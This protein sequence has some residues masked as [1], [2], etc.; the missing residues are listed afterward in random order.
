MTLPIITCCQRALV[1][2][3]PLAQAFTTQVFTTQYHTAKVKN[4]SMPIIYYKQT[5]ES[6]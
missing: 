6:L 4:S 1:K 3:Q 5:I 2:V